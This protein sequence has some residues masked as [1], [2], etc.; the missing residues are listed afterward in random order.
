MFV[1]KKLKNE[2]SCFSAFIQA[3]S[4]SIIHPKKNLIK[5]WKKN[6]ETEFFFFFALNILN[7]AA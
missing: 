3:R 4:S 2:C 5:M 1:K 7:E 6:W